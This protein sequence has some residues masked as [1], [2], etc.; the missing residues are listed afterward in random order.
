M[1]PSS[2]LAPV[3]VPV[4][5]AVLGASSLLAG[6]S[7]GAS[8]SPRPPDGSSDTTTQSSSSGASAGP[9]A[10]RA[11]ESGGAGSGDFADVEDPAPVPLEADQVDGVEAIS[12][13]EGAELLADEGRVGGEVILGPGRSLIVFVTSTGPPLGGNA[14]EAVLREWRR[15]NV[16]SGSDQSQTEVLAPVVVDGVEMLRARATSPTMVG[17]VFV[18]G[19]DEYDL[20]VLISTPADFSEDEREEAIGQVMATVELE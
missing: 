6:C 5:A 19:T 13:W 18:R 16:V 11:E 20:E 1:R 17:D 10:T 12:A 14:S 2:R 15:F 9:S 7:D 3:L 8:E 4:L